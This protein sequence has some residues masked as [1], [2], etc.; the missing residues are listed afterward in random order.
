[1]TRYANLP[2]PISPHV[3]RPKTWAR[4]PMRAR[5][6]DVCF[7]SLSLT[8]VQ[9]SEIDYDKQFPFRRRA[10]VL[11]HAVC[12]SILQPRPSRG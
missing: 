1:M 4:L 5:R 12:T 6:S 2:L 7:P 3:S 11:Y 10:N 8:R 9:Y